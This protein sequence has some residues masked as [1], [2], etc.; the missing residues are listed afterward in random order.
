MRKLFPL[1]IFVLISLNSLAQDEISHIMILHPPCGYPGGDE[2]LFEFLEDNIES[3]N[4]IN[5]DTFRYVYTKLTFDTTGLLTD[6]EINPGSNNSHQNAF[7]LDTSISNEIERVLRLMPKW[8][9]CQF[10]P[11]NYFILPFN[12]AA[13]YDS[14]VKVHPDTT[15]LF[16]KDYPAVFIKT[17]SNEYFNSMNQKI[18]L[19][20]YF[21]HLLPDSFV[22]K[23][24]YPLTYILTIEANG[25][26]SKVERFD[27]FETPADKIL[28]NAIS[29][30]KYWAPAYR[31][32]MH[33]RSKVFIE[34]EG[35]GWDCF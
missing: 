24:D 27:R 20:C 28:Y 5:V 13:P 11:I 3:S 34:Y 19:Q 21:S 6:L 33:C 25:I 18:G 15:A 23:L 31:D 35:D 2:K 4:F 22:E 29:R 1:V 9:N 32:G 12:F 17:D 26:L 14:L 7:P 16:I 30:M 8:E 10:Q